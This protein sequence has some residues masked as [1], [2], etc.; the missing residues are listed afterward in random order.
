MR[1]RLRKYKSEDY[2]RGF[3]SFFFFF[4]HNHDE[5]VVISFVTEFLSNVLSLF[6]QK[7]SNGM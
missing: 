3:S 1:A 7:Y 4:S 2:L 5:I 6:V